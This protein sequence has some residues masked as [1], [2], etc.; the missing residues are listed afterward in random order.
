MSYMKEI[1]SYGA[2]LSFMEDTSPFELIGALVKRDKLEEVRDDLTEE[3][4]RQLEKYDRDLLANAKRFYE[5]IKEVYQFQNRKPLKYWWT[6]ID[7]VASGKLTVELSPTGPEF[8]QHM[9]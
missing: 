8:K 9:A 1:H 7:L 3:E 5:L 2:D 6:N 4:R